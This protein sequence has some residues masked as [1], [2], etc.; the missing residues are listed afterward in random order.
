MQRRWGRV[1]VGRTVVLWGWKR[2]EREQTIDQLK[3]H[4]MNRKKER[5]H[6]ELDDDPEGFVKI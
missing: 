6:D 5:A 4:A 2:N 1:T 3:T